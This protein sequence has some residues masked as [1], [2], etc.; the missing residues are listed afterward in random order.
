MRSPPREVAH[1]AALGGRFAADGGVQ[2]A[3]NTVQRAQ[4]HVGMIRL[5]EERREELA[6][7]CRKYGV[8]KL[9][10]FGSATTGEFDPAKSDIDFLVEFLPGQD[11]GPWLAHYQ[12]LRDELERLLG[13]RV[14]LVMA[15]A[16]RNPYF[17]REVDRT[18]QVVYAA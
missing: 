7:L 10:V 1:G 5:L 11:L 2:P 13:R 12:D 3:G 16:A 14:D 15:G 8:A 4:Y 9:E 18:R 17:I 6:K